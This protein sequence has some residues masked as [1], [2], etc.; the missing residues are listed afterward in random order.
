MSQFKHYGILLYLSLLHSFLNKV[1]INQIF[2]HVKV[3]IQ[4]ATSVKLINLLTK[5]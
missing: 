3:R 4:T 2:N 5:L 1:I